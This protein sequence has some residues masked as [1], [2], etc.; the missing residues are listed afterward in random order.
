VGDDQE[1]QIRRRVIRAVSAKFLAA[2]L[3]GVNDLEIRAK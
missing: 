1:R 3:A 2:D